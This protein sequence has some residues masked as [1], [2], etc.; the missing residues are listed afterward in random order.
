MAA[1]LERL[2]EE[3]DGEPVSAFVRHLIDM[4]GVDDLNGQSLGHKVRFSRRWVSSRSPNGTRIFRLRKPDADT[5]VREGSN[6]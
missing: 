6:C 3:W 5:G 4:T 1:A 2:D